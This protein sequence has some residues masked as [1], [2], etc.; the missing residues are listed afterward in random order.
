MPLPNN[1][2]Y[3]TLATVTA[4]TRTVLGDYIANLVANPQGTCN[5]NAA[6]VTW[7]TGPK[8]SIYFNGAPFVVNGVG[9][10]V[11]S[12]SSPT[13][14]ILTQ[15]AGVQNAI[16]WACAI[17]T[18]DIFA[19]TQ[20]YVVPTVNLGWRKL[21]KKLADKGHPR[22]EREE[23]I[24]AVPAVTDLDPS[25]QMY[26]DWGGCFDGTNYQTSPT[27]PAD[28]IAPLWGKERINQ[29]GTNLT[30][31]HHMNMA[32]DGI[33]PRQKGFRNYWWDWRNDAFHF[34]GTLQPQDFRLRFNSYLPDFS[35]VASAFATTLVPIMRCA[36][37][38]AYYTAS[39]FVEPRG[40]VTAATFEAKGDMGVDQ[41]TNVWAKLQQSVSYSRIPWGGGRSRSV[42]GRF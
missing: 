16:P 29:V 38:L 42:I 31:F 21:Q 7:L 32:Q 5:V 24:L 15:S 35:A 22:L 14:L 36:E 23:N 13:S 2:P 4:L 39:I 28:F 40:G 12:I 27:L 10:T 6:V 1:A 19:D 34:S 37:S 8:F 30:K 33:V 25:S 3:D 17:Q 9:Y 41:I 18:G 11:L 26:L 20:A